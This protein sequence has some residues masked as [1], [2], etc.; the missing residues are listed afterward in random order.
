MRKKTLKFNSLIF[1]LNINFISFSPFANL[2]YYEIKNILYFNFVVYTIYNIFIRKLLT[3]T[4]QSNCNKNVRS[5]ITSA[6]N[7]KIFLSII[8]NYFVFIFICIF[9]FL[10][11]YLFQSIF[12]SKLNFK[13][14]S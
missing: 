5:Y 10:I 12:F 7:Q 1:H 2:S 8:S 13:K 4:S 9:H 11:I 3:L 14:N 6:I